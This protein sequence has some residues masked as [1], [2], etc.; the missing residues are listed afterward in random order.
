MAK[1]EVWELIDL[2][3]KWKAI[4]TKWVLKV[5][6]KQDG[7]INKFKAQ[8][9]AKGY[10]QKEGIDYVETFSLVVRFDS[11]RIILAIVAHLDLELHQMDVK[12]AFLN[13]GLDKEIYMD[14]PIGFYCRR[15]KA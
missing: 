3:P 1:N 7:S 13:G 2:P 6:C 10:T 5:K 11:I 12:I 4:G 9:V 15:A 8:L 14:Q